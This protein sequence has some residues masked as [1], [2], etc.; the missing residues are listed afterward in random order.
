MHGMKAHLSNLADQLCLLKQ[1]I[2]FAQDSNR[3]INEK[4]LAQLVESVTE[5]LA[6]SEEFRTKHA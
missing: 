5:A 3:P 2:A 6:A 1:F 4:R